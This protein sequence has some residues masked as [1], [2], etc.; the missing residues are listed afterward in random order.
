MPQDSVNYSLLAVLSQ[1][2]NVTM[3]IQLVTLGNQT[4]THLCQNIADLGVTTF[5]YYKLIHL[6]ILLVT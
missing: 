4:I 3:P 2:Q 1:L 6:K 5:N